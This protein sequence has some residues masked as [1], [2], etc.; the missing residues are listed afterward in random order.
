MHASKSRFLIFCCLLSSHIKGM[1]FGWGSKNKTERR[2]PH[3]LLSTKKKQK[4]KKQVTFRQYGSDVN[5]SERRK[6][7]FMFVLNKICHNI[8]DFISSSKISLLYL[9]I[10]RSHSKSHACSFLMTTDLIEKE[11]KGNTKTDQNICGTANLFHD[12]VRFLLAHCILN[13][14]EG[15]HTHLFEI[16]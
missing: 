11:Y 14:N 2:K 10:Y 7:Y 3:F 16:S 12:L 6:I 13:F 5:V 9:C 15:M 1:M 4:K 8:Q